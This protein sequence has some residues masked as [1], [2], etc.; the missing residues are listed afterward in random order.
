VESSLSILYFKLF[1]N[2]FTEKKKSKNQPKSRTSLLMNTMQEPSVVEVNSV[3]S[4]IKQRT[5]LKDYES[6]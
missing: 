5:V 6:M 2:I 3:Y 1:I 4:C